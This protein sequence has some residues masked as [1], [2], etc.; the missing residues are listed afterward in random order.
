M[1][2]RVYAKQQA[3]DYNI[4]EYVGTDYCHISAGSRNGKYTPRHRV[5]YDIMTAI[6]KE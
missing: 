2:H 6:N 5:K 3:Y 1:H 4:S